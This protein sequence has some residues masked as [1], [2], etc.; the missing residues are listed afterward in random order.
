MSRCFAAATAAA[1][2][3]AS[4]A[5][6]TG[7]AALAS[8]ATPGWYNLG[9]IGAAGAPSLATDGAGDDLVAYSLEDSST[10]FNTYLVYVAERTA[11]AGSSLR[12]PV[13]VSATGASDNSLYP[14]IGA[15][16][17]G[18]VVVAWYDDGIV[19][20][21]T[22]AA[23]ASAFTAPVAISGDKLAD[24]FAGGARISVAMD[25]AGNAIVVWSADADGTDQNNG[26]LLLGAVR[27]VA[28]SFASASFGSPQTVYNPSAD[29]NQ[30]VTPLGVVMGGG[31]A[32]VGYSANSID[33]VSTWSASNA[34]PSSPT[35]L[36]G[37]T[38]CPGESVTEIYCGGLSIA[39]DGSGDAIAAFESN[40]EVSDD[41][42]V[43]VTTLAVDS[44]TGGSWS[45]PATLA[46]GLYG[47][48]PSG[49]IGAAMS[50]DGHGVV[51]WTE[52]TGTSASDATVQLAVED[53]AGG[54]F[55]AARSLDQATAYLATD[56]IDNSGNVLA[57]WT[58]SST[59]S[60]LYS[61]TIAMG[62]TSWDSE[63]QVANQTSAT[64]APLQRTAADGNTALAFGA[65]VSNG[66]GGTALQLLGYDATG[67]TV[68][69][70]AVQ[71]TG[72]TGT[73]VSMSVAISGIGAVDPSDVSWDFGDGAQRTGLTT[74]HVFAQPKTYL[75]T[76]TATDVAGFTTAAHASIDITTAAAPS[77]GAHCIVPRL[78][79]KTVPAA[80]RALTKAN[81]RLG[82]VKKPTRKRHKTLH[83]VK[84][85][86]APHSKKP[87]GTKVNIILG[88]PRH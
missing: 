8:T 62:S 43:G 10:G 81:C 73:S 75:V 48:G 76:V 27:P 87:K 3:L 69:N 68:S 49:P 63:S 9:Y 65:S 20:T 40:D 7:T 24:P 42:N 53:T 6:I 59:S 41:T 11:A 1:V 52:T 46:A 31:R 50:P 55:G 17:A 72:H 14:S 60:T 38:L 70:L 29:P 28:G 88:Y 32:V 58:Q 54:G 83:V 19:Y 23:G 18:D 22:R 35:D 64:G 15:D 74:S 34:T 16:A 67:P 30:L 2:V 13:V 5:V 71:A 84:Q 39:V 61:G 77:P 37:T 44:E 56:G 78:I 21:S 51:A 85:S 80:K 45:G 36:G 25:S 57:T 86:V 66:V 82:R 47:S 4:S 26:D 12:T 79:G 33:Y